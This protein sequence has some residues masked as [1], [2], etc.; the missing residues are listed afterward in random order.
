MNVYYFAAFMFGI[1]ICFYLIGFQPIF[2]EVY[3]DYN[4]F[5]LAMFR[6][7][8]FNSILSW[9]GILLIGGAV[10]IGGFIL[11]SGSYG[12]IATYALGAVFISMFVIP[13][14]SITT[15]LPTEVSLLVGLF[16]SV[17]YMVM[18]ISFVR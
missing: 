17:S 9:E 12:N 1:T 13:I 8:L 18:L 3:A 15:T 6:D 4:E 7:L 16:F 2:F 11:G 10:T 14:S 5:S